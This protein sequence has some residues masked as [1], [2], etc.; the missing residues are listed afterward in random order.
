[1]MLAATIPKHKSKAADSKPKDQHM[2]ELD[3]EE[4][5]NQ[6]FKMK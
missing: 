5:F 2:G 4:K 1:M 6:F 3:S